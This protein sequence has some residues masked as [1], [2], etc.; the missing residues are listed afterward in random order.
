M[1]T[2][3]DALEVMTVVTACHH[4]T[5]PR[6]DDPEAT[7][8]TAKVWARVFSPW[9]LDLADLIAAV[10]KR[11]ATHAESPEP[12]EIIAFARDIRTDRAQRESR[13]QREV[14]EAAIDAKAEGRSAEIAQFASRFGIGSKE[15]VR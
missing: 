9:N 12:A 3:A 11:A 5:A 10:E 1:T 14:R 8:A 6:M 15:A 4:R 7:M 2:T 13:E